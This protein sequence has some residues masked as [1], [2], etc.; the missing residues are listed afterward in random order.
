MFRRTTTCARNRHPE[1]RVCYDPSIIIDPDIGCFLESLEWA[2]AN[3]ERYSGGQT[4]QIG[5]MVTMI[6]END[7][8]T[9]SILEPDMKQM[10]IAWID[11]VNHTL[12]HLR[13]QKDV[14]E[15]VLPA[16]ELSFP[17]TRQSAIICTQLGK[18]KGFILDRKEPA[19]RDSVGLLGVTATTITT[20]MA[21]YG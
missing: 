13:R 14:C 7:E 10:P 6:Q 17:S 16:Q 12:V 3:G 18:D 8:G 9:L 15:S 5:W 21:R 19:G 20:T 1:F 2:V 11:S 4:F